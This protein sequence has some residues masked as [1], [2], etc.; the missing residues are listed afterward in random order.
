MDKVLPPHTAS[1]HCRMLAVEKL[2]EDTR[3]CMSRV[4]DRYITTAI[5]LE[6]LNTK[7]SQLEQSLADLRACVDRHS[8]TLSIAKLCA[9]FMFG[10]FFY[11]ITQ[12]RSYPHNFS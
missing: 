6:H 4:D 10:A 8:L 11:C 1:L 9:S 5:K 12:Q 7:N 3:E 2:L